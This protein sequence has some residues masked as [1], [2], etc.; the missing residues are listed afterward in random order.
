MGDRPSL[1]K[2]DN[3]ILEWLNKSIA[4]LISVEAEEDEQ[5][6]MIRMPNKMTMMI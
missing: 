6:V 4:W 1:L 3:L 2:R 5:P